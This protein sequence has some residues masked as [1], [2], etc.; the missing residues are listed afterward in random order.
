MAHGVAAQ[1]MASG[2]LLMVD[3]AAQTKSVP[4]P[5]P[6]MSPHVAGGHVTST[7]VAVSELT[8]AS[9][10]SPDH[11]TWSCGIIGRDALTVYKSGVGFANVTVNRSDGLVATS[12][13]DISCV[14]PL[15]RSIA[16]ASTDPSLSSVIS[17]MAES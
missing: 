1:F 4:M 6:S 5:S 8:Q 2:E 14:I 15:E 17:S 9:S 11:C 13:A 12:N 16:A 7:V 10:P 3:P